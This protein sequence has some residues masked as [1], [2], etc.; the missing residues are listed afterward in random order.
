MV[1]TQI[2]GSTEQEKGVLGFY[3][4]FVRQLLNIKKL[5][6]FKS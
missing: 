2:Q 1:A 3:R 5:W 6:S 4:R